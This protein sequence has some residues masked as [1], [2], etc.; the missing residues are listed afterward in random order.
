MEHHKENNKRGNTS[1]NCLI[2]ISPYTLSSGW[3][4]M[5]NARVFHN[6]IIKF[7]SNEMYTCLPQRLPANGLL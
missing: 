6:A 3:I 4:V 2:V 7:Y 5:T 1:N